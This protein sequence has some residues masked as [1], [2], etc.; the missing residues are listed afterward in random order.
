M[1]CAAPEWTLPRRFNYLLMLKK[2]V[3][4]PLCLVEALTRGTLANTHLFFSIF[5]IISV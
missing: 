3:I 5:F 4:A 1:T 2:Q